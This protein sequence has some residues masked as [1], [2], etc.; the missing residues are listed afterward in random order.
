MILGRGGVD[1]DSGD[2][3]EG[4]GAEGREGEGRLRV[5]GLQGRMRD[6]R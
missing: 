1:G 5:G 4:E 6:K 2:A 3:S